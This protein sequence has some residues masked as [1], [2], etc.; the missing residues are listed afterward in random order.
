MRFYSAIKHVLRKLQTELPS[1]LEYHD[2]DHVRDVYRMSRF[3]GRAEG[4]SEYDLKL[5]L[6]AA[7]LHDSGFTIGSEK[8]EER[9]CEIA[10]EILPQYG[11]THE[12]ISRIERMIM[13]TSIPHKPLSHIEK[14]ICDADLDYLGREDFIERG[15]RLYRELQY[16]KVVNDRHSWNKIQEKFLLQHQY[17]TETAISARQSTKQAHLEQI[18]NE[19]RS[20]IAS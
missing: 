12:D 7:I 11:Y 3:I 19:I 13:A 6:T 2:V 9:S 1:W 20:Y 10:K 4:L 5:L 14:I 17:F 18:Q 16:L 8:H 15:D